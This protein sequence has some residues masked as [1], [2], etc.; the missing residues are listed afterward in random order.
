MRKTFTWVLCLLACLP[1]AV[2][3]TGTYA[4]ATDSGRIEELD[5]AGSTMIVGGLRYR[6]AV[7]ANVEIA[8]SYGAFTMLEPGMRIYYEYEVIS[9]TERRVVL[10]RELPQGVRLEET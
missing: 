8:G 1:V 7:D 3:A 4:L 6:V 5:F 10:I 9:R 2:Q